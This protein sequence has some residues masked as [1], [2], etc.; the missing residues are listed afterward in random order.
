MTK[1]PYIW[2]CAFGAGKGILFL[3]KMKV[4]IQY[5]G[6]FLCLLLFM[7]GAFARAE[8]G[9]TILG[10][11]TIGK[12]YKMKTTAYCACKKCTGKSKPGKTASGTIPQVN[13][14]V[15]MASLPFGTKITIDGKEYTVEDRGGGVKVN[16]VDIFFATHKEALAYG[17]KT[18]DV[19]IWGDLGP[20]QM[21]EDGDLLDLMSPL[22]YNEPIKNADD[23]LRWANHGRKK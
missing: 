13:K 16:H 4:K 9:S 3:F 15:S 5:F 10:P 11:Y 1:T 19:I 8:A 12:I 17:R 23:R 14:T 7:T 6:A 20:E 22:V 18:R 2:M 21:L